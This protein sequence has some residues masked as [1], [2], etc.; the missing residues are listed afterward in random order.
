[1]KEDNISLINYD[2]IESDYDELQSNKRDLLE[3]FYTFLKETVHFSSFVEINSEGIRKIL[4]K[5]KK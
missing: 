1:M 3:T 2:N 4:K 5:Y